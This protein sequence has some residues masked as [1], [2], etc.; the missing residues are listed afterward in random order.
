M[1]ERN[2]HDPPSIE[3][4]SGESEAAITSRNNSFSVSTRFILDLP[5]V[6][7]IDVLTTTATGISGPRAS[8]PVRLPR[9]AQLP[10][11]EGLPRVIDAGLDAPDEMSL[12]LQSLV[13]TP[14][15]RPS[16]QFSRGIREFLLVCAIG[17]PLAFI[18]MFASGQRQIDFGSIGR[19]LPVDAQ[20][21]LPAALPEA[22]PS[23]IEPGP[24]PAP[25]AE[26]PDVSLGGKLQG[27]REIQTAVW[28]Y[29]AVD[30]IPSGQIAVQKAMTYQACISA[31]K[32]CAGPRRFANIQFFDRPTLTSKIPLELCYQEP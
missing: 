13:G 32:K 1:I 20:A 28:T 2:D 14:S 10:P 8:A 27:P 3:C 16:R 7:L 11:V 4:R 24:I 30:L 18:F 5:A 12:V 23:R 21:L 6:H 9:A 22:P 25:T 26:M 15:M 29:C 19:V 31:G 17:A